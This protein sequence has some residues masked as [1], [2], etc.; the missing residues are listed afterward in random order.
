MS[1][2]PTT[3]PPSS[4]QL[5]LTDLR[6]QLRRKSDILIDL[7]QKI[8]VLIGSEE[9][10]E[11]EVIEAEDHCS[12]ISTHVARV[13]RLLEV[14]TAVE[15][16]T[17]QTPPQHVTDDT[18]SDAGFE[19]SS[20][21]E[22]PP[23]TSD[24]S[25]PIVRTRDSSRIQEI[26]RLPKL[27][28]PLFSGNVLEWQSFWDCFE[29]AVHNNPALSG[30]QKL[31]YLHAQL[32]GGA[33]RVIAGLPLTN[34]SYNHSV[35]LL[36]DRY[37]QP[38]KLISAHM[39]ALIELPGPSNS[40]ASL[41]TFYDAVEAHTRSLTSLGKPIDEYGSMLVT[42]ILGKLSVETKRNLARAHGSD[43]W[44][45][46]DLQLA[47]SNE[48]RILEMGIGDNHQTPLPT[49]SFVT[50][51]ERRKPSQIRNPAERRTTTTSCVYCQGSHTPV[52]C[53]NVK[54]LQQRLEIT[55]RD[56]LCFNC[57]GSHKVSQCR[58]KGRC[59]RCNRK[60]HTSLCAG[61]ENPTE[62]R[63]TPNE[64]SG[65]ASNG[66]SGSA[67]NGQTTNTTTT[68]TTLSSNHSA[69]TPYADRVCLLKTAIATVSSTHNETETNV[70]F[71]EGS[72]RSFLTRD[73]ADMLLLQP[74]G[75]EDI[76]IS[77]FG[78]K[79]PLS[80]KTD[81]AS[82]NLKTK[83]GKLIPL[84]VL[85]VP[86][87]AVPLKNITNE[88]VTQL[89]YLK[90]L[91]LAH[92]VTTDE[93]FR[94]S[95]L[96]GVDH[97]WD[98]IEDDII[99]GDGPTAVR[100]KLGYLL[101]GPL[102]VIQPTTI[103]HIGA[104][105]DIGCDI[106][107]YW[108]LETT[109][110]EPQAED[111]TNPDQQFFDM[112]SQNYITRLEDGSYCA[113]FPW[114]ENHPPLPS[115]FKTCWQRTRSL[116]RRLA[117]TPDLL[118][119]YDGIIADQHRRGFIERVNILT[120]TGKVHYIPHHCVKK[121]SVTTPIRVVYD[122]S[123]RQ[124]EYDPSLNDCLLRGPDFLNDLC[125]I[126]LR[127]RTHTFAIS[128]DIEKAFLQVHLHEKDRDFTR[129]F[130]LM[131]PS[132]P[133]SELAVYRFRTVLFGA[134]SSPFILYATLYHHL[135]QHN[136]PLSKD[137]QTNLYVDN[138][139]SG[140]ATEAEAVQYYHNARAMLSKAGFNL[141]AWMSNSQ[142]VCTI[143]ERDKTIDSSIPSNV[144][145]IH[146]NALTDQLS[147][148]SKGTDLTATE[149][150]TKRE[151][152]QESS[153]VFD[154]IGFAI[155]VTIRS[156]LLMQKLW[157]GKIEWDEPLETD[158]N[159]EWLNIVKDINRLPSISIDRRYT[160]TTFDPTKLKLHTFTDA[161]TKAYGA[162]TFLSS[163]DCVS[164]IMAKSRVAP[165]KAT[166]LPRLELMAAVVGARITRFIMTSLKLE[167]TSTYIW[168]D[169]QI[170]LYWI[171]SSK[172]LPP[173]IAHRIREIHQLI[174]TAIWKYCPTNS[175]PA[176]LPTRGLSFDQL[177]SSQLW[178]Q[179][180][181]WLPDQ[182]KWPKWEQS[183]TLH[184]CALAESVEK[185][186]PKDTP[187][188]PNTGLHRIITLTNYSTLHK[189]LAVTT[190]VHRFV[191]NC[192]HHQTPQTGPLSADELH[193][194]KMKWI[195]DCQREVYWQEI[196]NLS[197]PNSNHKRMML[198]RQ[199]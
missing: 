14:C 108:S 19:Q 175:N 142:Q 101:S 39:K 157:K 174:P 169:S 63:N 18:H 119:L 143:A 22:E 182:E 34:T 113:R 27:N 17:V 70:L 69:T 20:Q 166:T 159:K 196:H 84:S 2:I 50:N 51:T 28:I 94:I 189:L 26:T 186:A 71:D 25:P 35:T 95:L 146:W 29:T 46:A 111:G 151:V 4:T 167:S 16:S 130:W 131:N 41:Q 112:Y 48:I 140:S 163:D 45:I 87:I 185:S 1:N 117:R 154:P 77:S 139:I 171:H 160:S 49:A 136:T 36:N 76:C 9:D 44:T 13:T 164:F 86:D 80:Q 148:I 199:L 53:D 23:T 178:R 24:D 141:R 103:L 47:I 179:G 135:Q 155:P 90:G 176:D 170:V 110:T 188:P 153:R 137:I 125:S 109:G 161:S 107:R 126:L 96:I 121:N 85:I 116:A 66:T 158:L 12:L 68:L 172:K 67:S 105:K 184:L 138:I 91:P 197:R 115:N 133:E 147:L 5:R 194:A 59:R 61:M 183:A 21:V 124:S 55:K 191:F 144:L 192:L 42:S 132:D 162:V 97:Y 177:A 3:R 57:L 64:I 52:N 198:V 40:L 72:Q 38:H 152:L 58:S 30:V 129:F 120:T 81:V 128:T 15:P 180:P 173:F 190:Y 114:K 60:H 123:C 37:G 32:Q 65:N 92:P 89:P 78:A 168:T 31:N 82:I 100:S 93:N 150:T 106:Q 181:Q 56:R 102:P 6:D 62:T 88:R 43:E 98:I 134:V 149:L 99:R 127:F 74:T 33:L 7:D 8:S 195:A 118:H 145:G 75:K 73:I 187:R 10:L 122:C 54:D 165:L 104:M 156:K 83:S 193:K 79:T 11:R